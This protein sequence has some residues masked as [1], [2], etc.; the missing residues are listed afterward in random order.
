MENSM[1]HRL[2]RQMEV[3][4]KKNRDL[5]SVNSKI[6]EK[7][8]TIEEFFLKTVNDLKR[9]INGRKKFDHC[10]FEDFKQEDKL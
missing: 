7:S 9:K 10:T 2:E 5:S 4:R 8:S 6:I 1:V 3:L